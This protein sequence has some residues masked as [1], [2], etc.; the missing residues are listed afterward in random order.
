MNMR[1]RAAVRVAADG[2]DIV[3]RDAAAASSSASRRTIRLMFVIEPCA[4]PPRCLRVAKRR[5]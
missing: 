5:F 3:Y 4:S 1:A 2:V